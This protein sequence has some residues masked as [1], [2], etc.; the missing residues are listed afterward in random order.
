MSVSPL[1]FCQCWFFK[2]KRVSYTAMLGQGKKNTDFC[3]AFPTS[4]VS[5]WSR[6][7]AP[8]IFVYIWRTMRNLSK[9]ICKFWELVSTSF[10]RPSLYAVP[11]DQTIYYALP[12]S[13]A[14][15]W[16]RKSTYLS[17]Y[18][19]SLLS[20]S[21]LNHSFRCQKHLLLEKLNVLMLT[22]KLLQLSLFS[23]FP[24][25]GL[26]SSMLIYHSIQLLRATFLHI[27]C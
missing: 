18:S 17:R 2:G 15:R 24:H 26:L 12:D 13:W 22:K 8:P 23:S 20:K 5:A 1:D 6:N 11:D 16:L 25:S 21:A 4:Y 27:G 7:D 14:N 9:L 19:D 10:V 3:L